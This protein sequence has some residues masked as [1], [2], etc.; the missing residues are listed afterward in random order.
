VRP[1][2][3]EQHFELNV[4][5]GVILKHCSTQNQS[6]WS[7]TYALYNS[8]DQNVQSDESKKLGSPQSD[9]SDSVIFSASWGAEE[10]ELQFAKLYIFE[11][12]SNSE[13][14]SVGRR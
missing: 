5:F 4:E 9:M 14:A 7:L 1:N 6:I 2:F 8:W 11:K 12:S 3:L 10:S 13:S